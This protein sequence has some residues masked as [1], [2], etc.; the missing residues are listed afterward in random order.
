VRLRILDLDQS[1]PAQVP[2]RARLAEGR[3]QVVDLR[4]Q[5]EDF[6]LWAN[7]SDMDWL[8]RALAALPPPSGDGIPL[9]LVGSGDYHHLTIA[10]L[11]AL[12]E[13]V[14]L[15]HFDNHPDWVRF[16]PAFHC[17]SWVNRAL[18]LPLVAKVVTLGPCADDLSWPQTKGANLKALS[19]GRIEM[20]PWTHAPSRLILPDLLGQIGPGPGHESH[21]NALHWRN[22]ADQDWPSFIEAL[23]QRLPTDA[24]WIT[25]DKDVL[26]SE[27]AVTNWDQGQ[28]P[29]ARLLDALPLLARHRRIVGMD[30]CGEYAAPSF[31]NPLKRLSAWMDH[32]APLPSSQDLARNEETNRLL[33]ERIESLG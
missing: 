7:R 24:I 18:E 2:V 33:L 5:A 13:P 15:I 29:L 19:A 25:I 9:T 23:A 8:S 28:M 1:L 12:Q 4:R 32:P 14:T 21:D 16:P 20:Y 30:L 22:L 17:G 6:R 26:R 3:V 31:L 11:S 10:L 27:D